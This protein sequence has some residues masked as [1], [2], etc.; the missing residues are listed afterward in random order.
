MPD[1]ATGRSASDGPEQNDGA[2]NRQILFSSE[3]IGLPT[4]ENFQLVENPAPEPQ[5]GQIRVRHHFLALSPSARIRMSGNSD[6]GSGMPI[7]KPVQ[8]QALGIVDRTCHPEFAIGDYLVV[9]GGWQDFSITRG[10]SAQRVD[11]S[12]GPPELALGLLGT[13]GMTAYVGLLDYGMPNAGETLVVSAASGSVGSVVGQIAKLKGCR[14]VGITGGAAKCAYVTETLGFDASVDHRAPDFPDALAAACPDGID[15]SFE[16]V[17]GVVRDA[18]WPLLND[19]ARVVLCGMISQY[20][21]GAGL[22]G[23]DWF[24]ILTRRLSIRGFLLRDHIHRR[25]AFLDEVSNWYRQGLI[26][27]REDVTE[28]LEQAPAAFIRLLRGDNFGKSLVRL[29]DA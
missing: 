24:P 7:G 27:Y 23:P 17:G 2:M 28:G 16:N 15:I 18:V 20:Q 5:D 3:P 4:S 6:Y 19:K 14:V 22:H 25:A 13:S 29:G 21:D 26:H 12:L 11:L 10:G 8:G 9:N 1:A